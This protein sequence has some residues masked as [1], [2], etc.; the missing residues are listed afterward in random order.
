M[1]K[2]SASAIKQLHFMH[3]DGVTQCEIA[4]RLEINRH[5]V[6]AHL[7]GMVTYSIDIVRKVRLWRPLVETEPL[8]LNDA[9]LWLPGQP[10]GSLMHSYIRR[11]MLETDLMRTGKT[12]GRVK[13]VRHVVT[14]DALRAFCR[15]N[16]P[17]QGTYVALDE[18]P[19]FTDWR[20]AADDVERRGVF[21]TVPLCLVLG[22]DAQI[23]TAA[24]RRAVKCCEKLGVGV[25]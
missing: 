10:S 23:G 22:H 13:R 18:L 8:T 15:A 2:L 17:I 5:T 14:F 16:W 20:P 21:P 24:I 19:A 12:V 3:Q 25:V 1:K 9:S 11:G 6:R 7:D 4:R